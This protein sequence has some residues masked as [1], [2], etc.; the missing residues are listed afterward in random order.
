MLGW[1]IG[2]IETTRWEETERLTTVLKEEWENE[3]NS[4]FGEGARLLEIRT[5]MA[6]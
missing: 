4:G 5:V 2:R 3:L 1:L 6:P